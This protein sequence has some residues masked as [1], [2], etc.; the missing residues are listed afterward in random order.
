MKSTK[1]VNWAKVAKESQKKFT[2]ACLNYAKKE[3]AHKKV[4]DNFKKE[5]SEKFKKG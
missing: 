5:F 2:D 3:F 4:S 1:P